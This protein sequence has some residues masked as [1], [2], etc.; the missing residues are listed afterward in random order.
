MQDENNESLEDSSYGDS[1]DSLPDWGGSSSGYNIA[2]DN[3]SI[4]TP[5][6]HDNT[7]E[8]SN[9]N[10]IPS[11]GMDGNSSAAPPAESLPKYRRYPRLGSPAIPAVSSFYFSIG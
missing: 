9:S 11:R 7:S 8:D 2:I 6:Y 5:S 10:K 4:S 1:K 3:K